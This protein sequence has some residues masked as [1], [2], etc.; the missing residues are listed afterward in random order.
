MTLNLTKYQ[1]G[2]TAVEYLG[3]KISENAMEITGKYKNTILN[4]E[5][6]ANKHELQKFMGCLVRLCPFLPNFT[7]ITQLLRDLLSDEDKKEWNEDCDEAFKKLKQSLTKSLA[8]SFFE[9]RNKTV[10][11]VDQ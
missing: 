5:K 2:L 10:L 4:M 7:D 1:I 6:P 9:P 11:T 8:L 3:C